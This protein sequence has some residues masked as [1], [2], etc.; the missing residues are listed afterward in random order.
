MVTYA[1]VTARMVM[2]A[3]PLGRG[4]D[5]VVGAEVAT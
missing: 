5:A 4:E 2:A 3:G 1:V